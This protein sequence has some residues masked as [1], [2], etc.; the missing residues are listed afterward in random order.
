MEILLLL[1]DVPSKYWQV[2]EVFQQI[3][4]SRASVMERLNF[5]CQQGFLAKDNN[6]PPGYRFNTASPEL[7]EGVLELKPIY[8]ERRVKVVELI[9]SLPDQVRSFADAF[10][11]RKDK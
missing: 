10:K 7:A 2:E 11:F 1:S 5:L 6:D 3:Q 4:S 9:Y 8:R